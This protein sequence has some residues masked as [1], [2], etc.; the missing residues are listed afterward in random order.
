M[1][2]VPSH[3]KNLNSIFQ[4]LMKSNDGVKILKL[5]KGIKFS[6]FYARL[7]HSLEKCAFL[8]YGFRTSF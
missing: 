3:C 5:Y 2:I 6:S 8:Y 4:T 7:A 1:Q